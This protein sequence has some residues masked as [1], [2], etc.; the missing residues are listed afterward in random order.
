MSAAYVVG[1][2][3]T[4]GDELRFVKDVLEDVEVEENV[5]AITLGE[6]RQCSM[7]RVAL[8][9]QLEPVDFRVEALAQRHIRFETDPSMYGISAQEGEIGSDA[10]PDLQNVTS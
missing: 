5:E 8:V 10:C 9:P 1:T 2:C 4:K 3:D 6:R 7:D